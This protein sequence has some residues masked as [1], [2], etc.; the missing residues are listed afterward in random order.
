MNYDVVDSFSGIVFSPGTFILPRIKF[1]SIFYPRGIK[2][3]RIIV[4]RNGYSRIFVPPG[5]KR[6]RNR[7]SVTPASDNYNVPCLA[8]LWQL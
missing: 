7:Y 8:T 3:T 5:P 4:P 6:T 1:T 2:L